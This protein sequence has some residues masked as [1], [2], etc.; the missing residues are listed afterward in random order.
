MCVKAVLVAWDSGID[1]TEGEHVQLCQAPTACRVH[2]EQ[3]GPCYQA[4]EEAQSDGYLEVSKQKE[5][6]E[7]LVIEN[8]TIR[9]LVERL[10]PV[11]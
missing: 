1:V 3:D 8:V 10:D 7:R 9:D 2:R 5:A 11:E 4:A 6:V